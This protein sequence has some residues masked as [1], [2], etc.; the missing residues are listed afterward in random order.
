MRRPAPPDGARV[1]IVIFGAAVWPG[2]RPSPSLVRRISYG[3]AVAEANPHARVFCSGAIG[4][5]GPSE[6]QVMAEALIAAGVAPDRIVRD[7]ASRDTLQSAAAAARFVHETGMA[8][9]I[10]CSDRYHLPRIRLLL[11]LFGV[12]AEPGPTARGTGG[13]G[14]WRWARMSAREA[15]ALPY[16]AMLALARRRSLLRR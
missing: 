14:A 1:A 4:R 5:H 6:A 12:A 16:D 10:V 9:C 13:A 3:L 2:G 8:R 7:E 11:R 15:L